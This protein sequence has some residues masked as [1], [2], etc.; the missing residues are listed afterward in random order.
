VGIANLI[1]L[2]V[3]SKIRTQ[4]RQSSRIREMVIEG[5]V[6][7]QKGKNPRLIRQLLDPYLPSNQ[8]TRD[9]RQGRIPVELTEER[10]ASYR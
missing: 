2:P 7:I 4:A 9:E 3:A 10:K 1:F 5:A 6:T 8:G